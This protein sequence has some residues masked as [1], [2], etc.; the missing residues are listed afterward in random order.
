MLGAI[1]ALISIIILAYAFWPAGATREH[2]QRRLAPT[3]FAQ[4]Q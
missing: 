1:I 2:A 3:V 4:P